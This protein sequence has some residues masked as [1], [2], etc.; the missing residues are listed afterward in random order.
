MLT[1]PTP[2]SA[3]QERST[4]LQAYL[5]QQVQAAGGWL[6]F[7]DYMQAALYAPSLGYYVAGKHKFG[8]AGDFIT[9]PELSVH[10]SQ[11]LAKQAQP[12]L[13]TC[14]HPIILEF[15]AGTGAMAAAILLYLAAQDALPEA[16]W[17]LEPSIELQHLQQQTLT[18]RCPELLHCVEWLVELPQ[19]EFSGVVLANEVLDAMPVQRFQWDGEQYQQLGI[20]TELQ[21]VWRPVT[22]TLLAAQ[23]AQLPQENFSNGYCSEVNLWL[24]PWLASIAD[25]LVHGLVL[26]ID[27]GYPAA[28]YYHPNRVTG[29]LRCHYRHRA[30]DD[31]FFFPGIQDITAHVDFTALANAAID[32]GFAVSG[33]C[34]Q[35]AFLLSCGFD[36]MPVELSARNTLLMPYAMGEVFKVM[37]L[38]KDYA[39]PLLGFTLLDQRGKL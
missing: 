19:Q 4:Q 1:L 14:E 9:A 3:E 23:L 24:Q 37:A 29:T 31:P 11:C 13:A 39:E 25:K 2:S 10:F 26:L 16:Y 18:E 33:Y 38:T 8:A 36:Q 22:D 20:N 6:S 12:I 27:Y 21:P 28:E 30:H 7:A 32:A 17:I 15:G 34:H 5:Q 35:A